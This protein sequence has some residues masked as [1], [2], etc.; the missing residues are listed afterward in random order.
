MSSCWSLELA[1]VLMT[2]LLSVGCDRPIVPRTQAASFT[3]SA[4][5]PP[6]EHRPV[7]ATG[8]IHAIHS[9][10]LQT[11][12]IAGLSGR[13]TLTNF[14]PNGAKFAKGDSLAAFDRTQQ[15]DNAIHAKEQVDDLSHHVHQLHA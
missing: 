6:P 14:A 13:L 11:P 12:Q 1:A 10:T 8:I 5:A 4:Q 7:R 15:L 2:A 9:I 3:K